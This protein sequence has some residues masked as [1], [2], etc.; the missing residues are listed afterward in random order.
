MFVTR[1]YTEGVPR[2]AARPLLWSALA[3]AAAVIGGALLAAAGFRP[4]YGA[5]LVGAGGLVGGAMLNREA[6][7]PGLPSAVAGIM[8][9]A[10]YVASTRDASAAAGAGGSMFVALMLSVTVRSVRVGLVATS[11]LAAGLVLA[12]WI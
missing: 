3:V 6:R 11:I 2:A 5:L 8:A 12:M 4:V 9:L 10:V 1:C 7:V